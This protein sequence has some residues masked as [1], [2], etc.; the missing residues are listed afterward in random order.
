MIQAKALY[1]DFKEKDLRIKNCEAYDGD[2]FEKELLEKVVERL[3]E[4]DKEL[5]EKSTEYLMN[6]KMMI[7]VTLIYEITKSLSEEEKITVRKYF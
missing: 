7:I 6:I 3:D 5:F 2:D 1:H 4:I